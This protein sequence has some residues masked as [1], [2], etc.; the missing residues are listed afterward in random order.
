M[1]REEAAERIKRHIIVHQ[2]G[3][4]PHIKLAEALSMAIAALQEPEQPQV[5]GWIPVTYHIPTRE[6]SEERLYAYILDCPMPEE[7]Q[8]ILV[9]FNGMVDMDVCCYDEGW[10]LDN[11]GDWTDVDA[12]M[13]LPEPFKEEKDV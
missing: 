5:G 9:S 8:E 4:Y 1:T 10:Y 6:D 2:I 13:P 3:A 12:W 11:R 7:G